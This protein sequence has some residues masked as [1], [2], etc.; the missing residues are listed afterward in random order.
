MCAQTCGASAPLITVKA[1]FGSIYAN[2][3]SG[4]EIVLPREAVRVASELYKQDIG[5]QDLFQTLQGA[6]KSFNDTSKG[7]RVE[8]LM[9][10]NRAARSSGSWEVIVSPNKAYLEAGPW[11]ISMFSAQMLL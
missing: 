3:I 7:D 10:G 9:L 11:W 5:S 8:V 1:K 4:N 2:A 6:S